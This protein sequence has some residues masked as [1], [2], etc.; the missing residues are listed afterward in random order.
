MQLILVADFPKLFFRA[1]KV[2]H[3]GLVSMHAGNRG[4][5]GAALRSNECR[6]EKVI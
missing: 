6:A 3:E 2:F 1:G 5:G 4:R